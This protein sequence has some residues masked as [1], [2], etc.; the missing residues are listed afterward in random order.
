MSRRWPRL[1]VK[2]IILSLSSGSSLRKTW[3]PFSTCKKKNAPAASQN[4]RL[5]ASSGRRRFALR[6][7]ASLRKRAMDFGCLAYLIKPFSAHALKEAL[8]S[9]TAPRYDFNASSVPTR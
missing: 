3:S 9:L 4:R 8:A 6:S 2:L 7:E 1:G 5:C